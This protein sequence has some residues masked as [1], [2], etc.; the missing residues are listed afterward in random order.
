MPNHLILYRFLVR[1]FRS[2][3]KNKFPYHYLISQDPR[4]YFKFIKQTSKTYPYFLYFDIEK[5]FPLID[6]NIILSEIRLNY[7]GLT[8]KSLSR[9]FKYLLKKDLPQFLQSSPYPNKGLA[10]G[11]PLSHISAGIYLLKLDLSS[12]VPFLRFTDDYLLFCK[13]KSQAEE[14]LKNTIVPVLNGLGLSINIRKL[15]SGKFHQ[16]KVNFLGFEFY[17]GYVRISE[18]KIERFKQKIKKLTYLTR[19][20]TISS[21]Y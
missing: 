21:N 10:I 8:N 3:L 6:H 5:Y 4:Q 13:T 18:N 14:L 2:S 12:P 7:H 15:K 20:K 9:R 11:S 19:K 17:A 1:K 16:D